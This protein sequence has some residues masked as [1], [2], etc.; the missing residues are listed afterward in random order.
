[1]IVAN[2]HIA[3]NPND[4]TKDKFYD[5]FSDLVVAIL[6]RDL[7]LILGDFNA[8]VSCDFSNWK[9]II[10]WHNFPTKD[11]LPMKNGLKFLLFC[12]HHYPMIAFTFFQNRH[13]FKVTWHH[14]N[15]ALI[16]T[17]IEHIIIYACHLNFIH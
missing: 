17:Y 9:G 5:T 14:L 1:M 3:T 4:T 2:A 16:N 10:G 7:T 6:A 15:K 8:H 11:S 12:C 13:R